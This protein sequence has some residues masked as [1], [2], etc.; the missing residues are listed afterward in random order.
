MARAL[1]RQEI[2]AADDV[3]S[4]WVPVPEWG[5]EVYV[6]GLSVGATQRLYHEMSG[7]DEIEAGMRLLLVCVVDPDTHESIFGAEDLPELDKRSMAAVGRVLEACRRVMGLS[8]ELPKG[9]G[10]KSLPTASPDTDSPS[11]NGSERLSEKST[12]T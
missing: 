9:T 5:G 1:T 11:P 7:L 3:S 10:A 2:L 8:L 4:E 12:E 6:R